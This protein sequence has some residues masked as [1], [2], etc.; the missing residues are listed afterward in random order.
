MI[1]H[2][3]YKIVALTLEPMGILLIL[4]VIPATI[5]I[6]QLQIVFLVKIQ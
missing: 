2:N 1:L 6:L 5:A 4:Q 3:V